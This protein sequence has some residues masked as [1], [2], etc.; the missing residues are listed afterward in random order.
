MKIIIRDGGWVCSSVWI[1]SSVHLM[2]SAPV[3]FCQECKLRVAFERSL[4]TCKVSLNPPRLPRNHGKTSCCYLNRSCVPG[5]LREGKRPPDIS[6]AGAEKSSFCEGSEC[7]DVQLRRARV[8]VRVYEKS[9]LVRF[10]KEKKKLL[11]CG[12]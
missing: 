11:T 7:S 1:D 9:S 10:C 12:S 5:T 2:H 8:G 4:E 3:Q 6:Y